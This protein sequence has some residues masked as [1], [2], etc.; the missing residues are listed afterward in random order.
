MGEGGGGMR[1]RVGGCQREAGR[2][3]GAEGREG[4]A[5]KAAAG[6]DKGGT[7]ARQDNHG[8]M[9]ELER[10]GDGRHFPKKGERVSIH[11]K[12]SVGPFPPFSHPPAPLCAAPPR[13]SPAAAPEA[14]RAWR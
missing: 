11:Y 9:M 3:T 6:A 1:Q 4:S 5:G 14:C 13:P 2:R 8:I 10:G 7:L 12:A